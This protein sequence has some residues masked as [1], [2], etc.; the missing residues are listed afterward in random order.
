MRL[1]VR[2]AG[3]DPLT[4]QQRV[5][6]LLSA[7]SLQP[8][9]LSASAI[10]IVR[11]LRDPRP[12]TLHLQ[13][14]DVRPPP[15]WEQ[16]LQ[17]EIDRLA[18]EAAR[19]ITGAVPA[20]AQA[21]IFADRAEW[22]ACLAANW[23]DGALTT[24]W[25]W[26]QLARQLVV[27]RAAISIWLE[28]PEYIPGALAHLSARSQSVP[29]IRALTS[30]EIQP[31][32][33]AVVRVFG[34]PD[35]HA[36]LHRSL[37]DRPIDQSTDPVQRR[38]LAKTDSF[39]NVAEMPEPIPAPWHSTVPEAAWLAL[40]PAQ[41]ALLG[42]SLML[43]RA[44]AIARSA[45]FARQADRWLTTQVTGHTA[46]ELAQ[47]A[48]ESPVVTVEHP[49]AVQRIARETRPVEEVTAARESYE[50]TS[51]QAEAQATQRSVMN[52]EEE[53]L[54]PSIN[55]ELSAHQTLAHSP[56][57][58]DESPEEIATHFGSLFYL[59]N[60]GLV[61]NLYADFSQSLAPGIDLPIW[62]FVALIGQRLLGDALTIDPVWALLARLAQRAADE[63]P[64][65]HFTAPVEWRMPI[66]WLAAFSEREGWSW[67]AADNRLRVFHPAG[68]VVI[69]VERTPDDVSEQLQAEV[70]SCADLSGLLVE[71][72]RS[73]RAA[74]TDRLERWLNWLMPYLQ[75]RLCLALGVADPR[76]LPRF[77]EHSG[78]INLT[79]TRLDVTLSLDDLPIEIRLA[80]L[81][82]DPGWVPAAGR[83]VAFHFA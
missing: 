2:A 74:T 55:L 33:A 34:L 49:P 52:R 54:Q 20:N 80:G 30:A 13:Y 58:N 82:R 83:Y 47:P 10:L 57:E 14:R 11:Q 28:M 9:E 44:P 60:V 27:P 29:F 78:R 61:L 75:R 42:V 40:S 17:S 32:I 7:V 19:P 56:S 8:T 71:R 76:D 39:K 46:A 24:H 65:Q 18:R 45:A 48:R 53:P 64:G 31:M 77:F 59:I 67:S 51:P 6:G 62:D 4:T 5:T 21:V 23:L 73:D 70:Q 22:L 63:P 15:A 26:R 72:P 36:A 16:A 41:Q 68:F 1:R 43:E 79:T 25:W 81:D 3:L 66:A 50:P 12:G 69:D 38:S 35:L 37:I